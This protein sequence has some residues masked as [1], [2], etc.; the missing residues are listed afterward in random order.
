MP[1]YV[2]AEKC[3]GCKGQDKT[4]CM[5]ICPNDL[6][7]LDKERMK[8]YQRDPQ[9]CWECLCC[10][11]ICPQQAIDLRGYADFVPMGSKCVPLRGS[12]DIM[13]TIQFRD[14]EIKRFKFPIRT[15]PEGSAQPDGGFGPGKADDINSIYLFTEPDSTGVEIPTLKK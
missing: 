7:V 10:G 12:Q 4:A 6:M 1:A 15:T 3:D 13:W 8:A 2:I 14:G 9:M 5:Y 11:K